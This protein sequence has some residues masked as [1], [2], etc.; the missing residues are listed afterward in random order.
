MVEHSPKAVGMSC[1]IAIVW[2]STAQAA[3]VQSLSDV[4]CGNIL[5]LVIRLVLLSSRVVN[6]GLRC[7]LDPL[8]GG[9]A[10]IRSAGS[11]RDPK[12]A[13]YPS[14]EGFDA[15]VLLVGHEVAWRAGG[16]GA[17]LSP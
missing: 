2:D 7:K 4:S 9:S 5:V 14:L 8:G 1:G 6:L 11:L 13:S 12:E 3:T 17:F 15:L 16:V 10:S